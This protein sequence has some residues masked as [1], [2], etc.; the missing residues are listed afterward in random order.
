[1]THP[2]LVPT[3]FVTF[4]GI[5][6][7]NAPAPTPAQIVVLTQARTGNARAPTYDDAMIVTKG[8]GAAPAGVSLVRSP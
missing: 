6:P 8:G 5:N 1:M 2:L 7:A 4:L 3:A